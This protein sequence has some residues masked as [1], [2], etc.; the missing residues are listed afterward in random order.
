MREGVKSAIK[1][2][3]SSKEALH[4]LLEWILVN[5][6]AFA[7]NE[8]EQHLTTL[9]TDFICRRGLLDTMMNTP[10]EGHEDLEFVAVKYKE[11]IYLCSQQTEQD[12]LMEQLDS[13]REKEMG[14]WGFKFEQY[15][16]SD[17]IPESDG[18]TEFNDEQV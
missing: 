10:Y 16:L 15:M 2:D 6:A 8:Q 7:V 3:Y 17:N 5:K 14:S 12:K 13:E 1:K 4:K 9:S 18:K 11:T